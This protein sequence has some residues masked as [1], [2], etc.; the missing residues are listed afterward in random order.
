VDVV[1]EIIKVLYD[2]QLYAVLLI[3]L[4]ML[5]VMI[6][7]IVYAYREAEKMRERY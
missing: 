6:G 2:W 1:S 4:I 5:G 7:V 3:L